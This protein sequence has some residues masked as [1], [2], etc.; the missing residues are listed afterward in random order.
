MVP[1][2]RNQNSN[3]QVNS[4]KLST[5]R[6]FIPANAKITLQLIKE[7]R[8][9]PKYYTRIETQKYVTMGKDPISKVINDDSENTTSDLL[10]T[11]HNCSKT[12]KWM[13]K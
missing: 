1:L 3:H 6:R 10:L 11:E 9:E 5:Q 4:K 13:V 12:Q 8:N 7:I 2:T